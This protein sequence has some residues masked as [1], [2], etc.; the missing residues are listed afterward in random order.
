V[1]LIEGTLHPSA[2]KDKKLLYSIM[3]SL[4]VF[5]GFSVIR[6]YSLQETAEFIIGMADKIDRDFQKGKLPFQYRWKGT[7]SAAM[8]SSDIVVE[9]GGS[10]GGGTSGEGGQG[11]T[12]EKVDAYCTVVKKVKKENITPENMGEI[13][14]CQI[15]GIS[16]TTAIAVM[17]HVGGSFPKLMEVLETDVV[18]LE[19]ILIGT[20]NKKRKINKKN[21]ENMKLYLLGNNHFERNSTN[22]T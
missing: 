12:T 10:G 8:N 11:E 19:N 7:E 6:T 5:K 16:S 14:L 21:V 20:G 18:S 13:L 4:N 2:T 17:G 1:Y 3:T 22:E 9:S 15:P